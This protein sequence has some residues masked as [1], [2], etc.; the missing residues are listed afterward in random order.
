MT[1]GMRVDGV[2]F[3]MVRTLAETLDLALSWDAESKTATLSR[4]WQM[5][6]VASGETLWSISQK[7]GT[8]VTRLVELNQDKT[9]EPLSVGLSLRVK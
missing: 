9:L 8:T 2:H 6:T 4:N 1:G 5:H 7:Y 3:F